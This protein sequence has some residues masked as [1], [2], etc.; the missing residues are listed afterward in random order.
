MSGI[1][2]IG[3]F[4]FLAIY[5]HIRRSVMS[6]SYKHRKSPIVYIKEPN[7]KFGKKQ[8]SAAV[9][10]AADVPNGKQYKKFYCSWDISDYR[11]TEKKYTREEFR[12]CWFDTAHS[13]NYNH[14]RDP[15]IMYRSCNNWREA[16]RCYLKFHKTK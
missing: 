15:F 11:W 5:R 10:R 1:S 12:R 3:S 6:R 7:S 8:A 4:K 13:H 16:Y 2:Y 14:Q 9:R